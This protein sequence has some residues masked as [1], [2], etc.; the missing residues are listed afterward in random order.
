MRVL[1]SIGCGAALIVFAASASGQQPA[2][3]FEENCAVCHAIGGPPGAAPDLK[4]VTNR[5]AHTWLVRFIL[6]PQAA[7]KADPEAAALVKEFDDVMPATEGATPKLIDEILHYIEGAS[8]SAPAAPTSSDRALTAA[9]IAV[10]REI[11]Q[12]RRT[13]AQR[14]PACVSCHRVGSIGGLGGGTLGPDLTLA[15]QRLGGA[16]GVTT[17]LS[18]P[19]TKVMRAVYRPQPLGDDERFALAAMLVDESTRAAATP[20]S[21]NWA[22]MIVGAAGAMATLMLM[23]LVWSRRLTAVRRPLVDA[24]RKQAGD[25]R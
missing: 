7:A 16:R 5:R 8:R 2:K 3:Y 17:W 24:A 23:A 9:D 12:G 18:N 11:Y 13:L 19:P 15:S 6:N 20:A 25:G 21:R 22:F 1:R 14:A 4:N 10:G